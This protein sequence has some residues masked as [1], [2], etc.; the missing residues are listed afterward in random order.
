ME[1]SLHLQRASLLLNQGRVSDAIREVK[2]ALAQEPDNADALALYTRCFYEQDKFTEGIEM[3]KNAIAADPS[4]SY[5]YY[6]KA[7]GHYRLDQ[8]EAAINHLNQALQ[9]APYSAEYYGLLAMVLIDEKKFTVALEKADTGL[10]LDPEN[11]TCLNARSMALN[12]LRKTEEAIATMQDAL[13]KDPDNEYTHATI[14]WNYLE[15]GKHKD[16]S[17]HFREALRLNPD[18]KGSKEGLKEALKSKIPPYRWLLQYSFWIHNKG[19][20]ARWVIPVV[21]YFVVRLSASLM[22]ASDATAIFGGVIIVAYLIF[23]ITSWI[24]NPIANFFLLFH[25]DG[26]HAVT[27]TEKWTAITV[28]SALVAGTAL[29][30]PGMN[31]ERETLQTSL[32]ISGLAFWLSAVSLGDIIYPISWKH[33]SRNNKIALI[34]VGMALITILSS[35]LYLPAAIIIG[36]IYVIL[37]TLNNW[38]GVF[39]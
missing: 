38:L 37:F 36:T 12:K 19:K 3:I 5:Y 9:L 25:K 23:V 11:I 8:H 10:S 29:L 26:K 18:H 22:N 7:F 35:F 21:L 34:L 4:A 16:A 13:S 33:T 27:L 39:R 24:I 15:K 28:V 32:I 1:V 31:M 17:H 20:K 2:N 30:I 6:L 14:G